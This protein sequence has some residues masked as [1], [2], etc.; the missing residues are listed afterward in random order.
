VQDDGGQG[1]RKRVRFGSSQA[2]VS[3]TPHDAWVPVFADPVNARSSA[4]LVQAAM[5]AQTAPRIASRL[6][7]TS[8]RAAQLSVAAA[9]MFTRKAAVSVQ[10]S[11]AIEM[12]PEVL[13]GAARAGVYAFTEGANAAHA[14]AGPGSYSA[15]DAETKDDEIEGYARA[16]RAMQQ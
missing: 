10:R 5:R 13:A 11:N 7:G 4:V 6:P 12:P 2:L 14:L 8:V 15:D 1:G 16:A 3:P 9:H